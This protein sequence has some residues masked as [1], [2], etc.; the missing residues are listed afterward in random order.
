MHDMNAIV[1][2]LPYPVVGMYLQV[3]V[4]LSIHLFPLCRLMDSTPLTHSKHST[5]VHELVS[6]GALVCVFVVYRSDYDMYVC[7]GMYNKCTVLYQYHTIMHVLLSLI[8][9]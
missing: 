4:Q 7:S 9:C 1:V 3:G 5:T 2:G 8:L 6:A